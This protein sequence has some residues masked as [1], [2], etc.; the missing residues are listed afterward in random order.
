MKSAHI[1]QIN[2]DVLSF[3]L[4]CVPELKI[5]PHPSPPCLSKLERLLSGKKKP[6]FPSPPFVK[7]IFGTQH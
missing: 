7:W 3:S 5:P 2:H 1:P 6:Y 4:G